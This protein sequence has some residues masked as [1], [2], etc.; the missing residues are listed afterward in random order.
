MIITNK[1]R[2]NAS[3]CTWSIV[4]IKTSDSTLQGHFTYISVTR[5]DYLSTV[6]SNTKQYFCTFLSVGTTQL[7]DH[8]DN[9]HYKILRIFKYTLKGS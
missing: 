7:C 1:C 8:S 5:L 6:Q 9:N 2:S 3:I 4:R